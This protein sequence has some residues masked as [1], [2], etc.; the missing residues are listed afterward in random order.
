MSITQRR[1]AVIDKIAHLNENEHQ[2]I[3]KMILENMSQT[4]LGVTK[5]RNGVFINIKLLPIE[6][7]TSI[8]DFVEFSN[9]NRHDLDE[10][11]KCINE[12]KLNK[13]IS[14]I[15]H[16]NPYCLPPVQAPAD[17]HDEPEVIS[18][19]L[20][21]V[22]SRETKTHA[23]KNEWM[24]MLKDCKE[25]DRVTHYVDSLENNCAKMNKK[26]TC[27]MKYANAK[28]RYARRIINE[29]KNELDFFSILESELYTHSIVNL[30]VTS[31]TITKI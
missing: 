3:Y 11:D 24:D 31:A 27:N 1:K 5:N 30:S 17:S 14:K 6:V 7:I 15:L 2:E 25:L 16:M 29:K 10:Y 8:E 9:S 12:C 23:K 4:D 13:D 18:N 22:I 20:Q 21:D 26:K 28:K 19:S